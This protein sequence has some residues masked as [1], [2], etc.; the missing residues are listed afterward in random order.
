MSALYTNFHKNECKEIKK[1]ISTYI[2]Y[3]FFDGSALK[4]RIR[5]TGEFKHIGKS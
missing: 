2:V 1:L 4:N 3:L 5:E